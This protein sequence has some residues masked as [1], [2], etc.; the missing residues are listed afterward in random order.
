MR[1]PHKPHLSW[2]HEVA[3]VGWAKVG[4]QEFVGVLDNFF[5]TSAAQTIR[6]IRADAFISMITLR[7]AE[8]DPDAAAD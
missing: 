5:P 7:E 1:V 8:E 2:G 4:Q 3:A 6:W